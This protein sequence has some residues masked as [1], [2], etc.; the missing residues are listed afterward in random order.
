MAATI[1]DAVSACRRENPREI[2]RIRRRFVSDPGL[3]MPCDIAPDRWSLLRLPVLS[4]D[5]VPQE[6]LR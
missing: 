1:R 3:L 2:D 4:R 6:F 5:S